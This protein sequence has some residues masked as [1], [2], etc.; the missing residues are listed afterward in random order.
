MLPLAHSEEASC[1]TAGS[2]SSPGTSQGAGTA[3]PPTVPS[4]QKG[5]TASG[6]DFLTPLLPRAGA[7]AAIHHRSNW[8]TSGTISELVALTSSGDTSFL[9]KS[10]EKKK[11]VL[12]T[13]VLFH[14][15]FTAACI[16]HSWKRLICRCIQGR[17]GSALEGSILVAHLG[18]RHLAECIAVPK[19]NPKCCPHDG[20]KG[21]SSF[22]RPLWVHRGGFSRRPSFP[23][24][25]PGHHHHPLNL[26]AKAR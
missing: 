24:W 7:A 22:P 12:T 16:F 14:L 1:S 5:G 10:V 15:Q 8:D 13:D 4:P 26:K 11:K 17:A 21:G 2:Q 9:M 3:L 20:L 6:G 18:E 25:L 23:L 19:A